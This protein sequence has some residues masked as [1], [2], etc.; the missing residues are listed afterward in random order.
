[1]IEIL[2]GSGYD[3]DGRSD[4]AM[5]TKSLEDFWIKTLRSF[6]PYGIN[7][8]KTK[9]YNFTTIGSLYFSI[10]RYG[11]Q[12]CRYRNGLNCR[13]SSNNALEFREFC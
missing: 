4:E 6:S 10:K 3:E 5:L 13:Q 1:M 7:E 9:S 8:R 12:Y 11:Q 2:D